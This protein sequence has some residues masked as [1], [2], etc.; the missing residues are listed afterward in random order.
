M[1]A[2]VNI[3]CRQ[4][5]SEHEGRSVPLPFQIGLSPP[6]LRHF[7]GISGNCAGRAD[8]AETERGETPRGPSAGSSMVAPPQF[9]AAALD[10]GATA[11]SACL[12]W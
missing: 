10:S 3:A 6:E 9:Q 12:K 5:A 7:L 8:V 1:C 4:S 11:N 2:I